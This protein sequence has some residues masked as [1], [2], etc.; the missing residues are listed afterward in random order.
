[1]GEWRG[2]GV[3]SVRMGWSGRR[4]APVVDGGVRHKM[5]SG[6]GRRGE[7]ERP[8]PLVDGELNVLAIRQ[9]KVMLSEQTLA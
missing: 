8:L 4:K 6:V 9:L 5:G 2:G 7:G 1:M 3:E